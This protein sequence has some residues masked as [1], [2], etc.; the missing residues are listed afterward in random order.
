M[1]GNLGAFRVS[2]QDFNEWQRLLK[3]ALVCPTRSWS[4]LESRFDRRKVR[5]LWE[6]LPITF[7]WTSRVP[8]ARIKPF[9][10][11]KTIV[12]TIQLDR[13]RGAQFKFCA[14][15][16]CRRVFEL[17]SHPN[18]IYCDYECAHLVAVRNSRRRKSEETTKFR[19]K[20]AR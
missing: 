1:A 17:E 20:E 6:P 13:L 19:R 14:R 12:A 15:N 8:I 7:D 16:D 18:R 11:L 3:E 5:Q 4:K 10:A 2:Q 9:S